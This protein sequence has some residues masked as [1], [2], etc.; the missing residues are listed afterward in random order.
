M[1]WAS[2]ADGQVICSDHGGMETVIDGGAVVSER[3]SPHACACRCRA[4][5]NVNVNDIVVE[6]NESDDASHVAEAASGMASDIFD[7]EDL[8]TGFDFVSASMV[9][10]YTLVDL[11]DTVP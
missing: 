5:S 10:G 2:E 7:V 9:V 11:D 6:V 1:E 8:V 4:I 3:G